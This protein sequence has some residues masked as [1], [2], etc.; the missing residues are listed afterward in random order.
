MLITIVHVLMILMFLL[1]LLGLAVLTLVK[2]LRKWLKA[3]SVWV[4]L[5]PLV[6]AL[7]GLGLISAAYVTASDFIVTPIN[8]EELFWIALFCSGT[9]LLN[10]GW[11]TLWQSHR[12][13]GRSLGLV[14][15]GISLVG[16]GLAVLQGGQV[17]RAIEQAEA[18]MQAA[19]GPNYA[20][21]IPTELA[22][23]Q[24]TSAFSL[25]DYFKGV[26]LDSDK[27]KLTADIVYRTVDNQKLTLDIYEP[28]LGKA[29][30]LRP[31]LVVV[32]GGGWQIGDKSELPALNYYLAARGWT[33]F[34]LNYRLLPQYPFPYA[35]E[36]V[37]C[38]LAYINQNSKN[39]G[40]DTGRMTILGRSAGATMALTTAYMPSPIGSAATCGVMP[41]LRG[42]VSYYG[43]TNMATWYDHGGGN[44][45]TIPYL[46]G[47]PSQQ[48]EN[49]RL[50]SPLTYVNRTLP[51]TLLIHGDKDSIVN[52]EQSL[53]LIPRLKENGN[54]VALIR[55]AWPGH[56]FDTWRN[57][58][59]NQIA[60]Y[61]TER[62][63]NLV[64]N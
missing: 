31:T 56:G 61:Y 14:G 51:P 9:L 10:L 8:I 30:A 53:I 62:F 49:Y 41:A 17:P 58:F 50:A 47:T 59:S 40:V 6:L 5:V 64:T 23:T 52:I 18:E 2:P 15:M 29:G 16:L 33:V 11:L 32:H 43:E 21:K 37:Q 1:G 57:G 22:N 3:S 13:L 20:K 25:V 42:V 36:D 28:T 46:G 27:V 60:L 35:T 63:L 7:M 34:S 45:L 24:R 54:Q 39:Y 48:P 38:A 12:V 26:A 44:S 4:G 19:F 55:I